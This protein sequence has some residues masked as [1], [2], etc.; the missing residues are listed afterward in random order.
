M[1]RELWRN[2]RRIRPALLLTSSAPEVASGIRRRPC[3][4]TCELDVT[5]RVRRAEGRPSRQTRSRR[6]S[7][8]RKGGGGAHDRGMQKR[9]RKGVFR[10]GWP[11]ARQAIYGHRWATLLTTLIRLYLRVFHRFCRD[12]ALRKCLKS[13][14]LRT[15]RHAE[16]ARHAGGHWFK[17]SIAQLLTAGHS[18]A[19]FTGLDTYLYSYACDRPGTIVR[20]RTNGHRFHLPEFSKLPNS[21][22]GL[23]QAQAYLPA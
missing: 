3:G 7:E 14:W 20:R 23:G 17:S 21:G 18:D 8:R 16:A 2:R 12:Q 13:H 19:A 15:L 10:Q 6:P 9:S 22:G 1:P 5:G 11:L 4:I